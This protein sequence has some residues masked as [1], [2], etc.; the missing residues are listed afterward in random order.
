MSV[1]YDCLSSARLSPSL[2]QIVSEDLAMLLGIFF[3]ILLCMLFGIVVL[4]PSIESLV[5]RV[6]LSLVLGWWEALPV[7][8]VVSK[9]LLSHR[10]T[11]KNT[12]IITHI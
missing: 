2:P 6:I 4:T 10:D 8:R 12:H 3:A 5:Q 7:L 11:N 1:L 9:N